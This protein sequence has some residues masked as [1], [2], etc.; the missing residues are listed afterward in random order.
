MQIADRETHLLLRWTAANPEASVEESDAQ[1]E[2]V[3]AKVG[4]RAVTDSLLRILQSPSDRDLWGHALNLLWC[5][6]LNENLS[7]ISDEIVATTELLR[8]RLEDPPSLGDVG[9]CDNLIWSIVCKVKGLSYSI[10]DWEPRSDTEI[11]R[12]ISLFR[13]RADR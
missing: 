5:C 8:E 7:G 4:V 10:S 1:E 11:V 13:E 9:D 6:V 12:L 3:F 2:A